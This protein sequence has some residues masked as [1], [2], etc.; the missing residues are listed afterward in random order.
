MWTQDM[1]TMSGRIAE[2]RQG[3]YEKL[4]EKGSELNWDHIINQ[5]GMFAF[6]GL[7]Q[8]QCQTL[9]NDYKIYLTMNGRISV[10]GLNPSNIDY[11]AQAFHEVTSN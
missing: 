1:R 8:E 4:G 9:I 2:M 11:V 6:T 7:N 10:A 5:I 3:L